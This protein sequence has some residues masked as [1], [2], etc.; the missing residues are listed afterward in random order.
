MFLW[1]KACHHYQES[2]NM[3]R[4]SVTMIVSLIGNRNILKDK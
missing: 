2:A 3:W 4:Q 1:G